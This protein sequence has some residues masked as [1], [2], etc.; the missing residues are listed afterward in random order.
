MINIFQ[1]S[2]GEEELEALREVFAS[3]WIGKGKHVANFERLFAESLGVDVKHFTSTNSGTEAIFLACE[4]FKFSVGDEIIVPSVSFYSVGSAIVERG[5]KLVL[6]DVDKRTLNTTAEFIKQKITSNTKAVFLNHYGGIPC[7]M[8][9]ILALC[10][11]NNILVIE[12]AACGPHSFYNGRAVGTLGDMG[13]WSFHATKIITTGDGGMVYLKDP[14]KMIEAKEQL[15]LGL[16]ARLTTGIESSAVNKSWW[17]IQLNRPGRSGNINDIAGAIGE[18]QIKKMPRFIKRRQEIYDFYTK[19][20]NGLGW[21]TLPPS[22]VK[23]VSFANYF[24]WI[25]LNN[26]DELA[27][28]L[29]D[30][31]IYTAYRYW[32]LHRIKYFSKWAVDLPNS[33]F[34]CE[35]T[36]NLPIHQ[37]LS[38]ND[39]KKIVEAI[40]EFGQ[41]HN[42]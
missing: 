16:A 26:R 9:P 11:A 10:R 33:D 1:P 34:A 22:P 13:L 2:L 20:L 30:K 39:I 14:Q 4:L 37:G 15:S 18:V 41:S 24:Y 6:C 19:E 23:N 21:L 31:G 25:Q 36:L 38:D 27:R 8:D 28:F 32:P 35:Q 3:N 12:D 7:D 17:E 42:L 5:A 29:L 40:K